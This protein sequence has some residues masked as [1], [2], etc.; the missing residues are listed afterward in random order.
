MTFAERKII[1]SGLPASPGAAT[2][3]I[4]F[5]SDEAEEMKAEYFSEWGWT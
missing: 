2:G 4:V 3:A 5:S 1:G